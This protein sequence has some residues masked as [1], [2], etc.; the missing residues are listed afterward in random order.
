MG[1]VANK[2]VGKISFYTKFSFGAGANRVVIK[3]RSI[4]YIGASI[5]T[6]AIDCLKSR[7]D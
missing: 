6:I 2:V 1:M 5:V 7:S 4:S 3:H